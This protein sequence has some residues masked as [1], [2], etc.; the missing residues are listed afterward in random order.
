MALS[1]GLIEHLERMNGSPP[2]STDHCS[3]QGW[4]LVDGP[5]KS[6]EPMR[7]LIGVVAAWVIYGRGPR[8]AAARS[9][10]VR[11]VKGRFFVDELSGPLSR[12]LRTG[13]S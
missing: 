13:D 8:E 2:D 7:D 11:L 1:G 3:F 9:A 10:I 5:R 6:S 12:R 4:N